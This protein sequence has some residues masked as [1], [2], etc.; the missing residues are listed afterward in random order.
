MQH[1]ISMT[2]V[3]IWSKHTAVTIAESSLT[4]DLQPDG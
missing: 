3:V 1:A 4:W 2:K